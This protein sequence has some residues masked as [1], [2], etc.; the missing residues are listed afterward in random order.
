MLNERENAFDGTSRSARQVDRRRAGGFTLIELLVVIAIIAILAAML[1][2]AL[3]KAKDKAKRT[4]CMNNLRQMSIA[5]LGYAFD[6]N[7]KFPSGAGG[8]WIWDLPRSAAD[9]ML[10]ANQ[11]FLKVAFCPGTATRFNDQDNLALWNL[12]G[13]YR[14]VGYALTLPGTPALNPTNHNRRVTPEP[15]KFGPITLPPQPPTDRVFIA[16]ATISRNTENDTAKK[17]SGG[18]HYDDIDTGSFAKRHLTP[19]M[20]GRVPLGGNLAMLDGHIEWRKFELMVVRGS[21]VLFPAANQSC[22]T[23]WW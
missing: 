8:F 9:A 5:M 1:L 12:T 3:S 21:G 18:Y 7:D 14:A 10:A 17:Y 23:F 11:N 13:G 19:H 2:P 6:N 16:D 22:P 15:I 20:K 4:Q